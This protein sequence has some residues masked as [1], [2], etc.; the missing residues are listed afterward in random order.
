MTATSH[1]HT[2]GRFVGQKVPQRPRLLTGHG[3]YIDDVTVTGMLHA[4]FVRSDLA[5]ARI[6]GIDVE[7]ARAAEGVAAV[8]TAA[9]LNDKVAVSMLPTLFQGA[10]DFMAP[11]VPLAADDV[12][13]V[14]DPVALVIA[15]SRYLAEDAAEL[16]EVDYEPL[17]AVVDYE[18]AAS[19]EPR[20]PEPAVERGDGDGRPRQRRAVR[21]LGQRRARHRPPA[22]LQHGADGVPRCRVELRPIRRDARRALLEPE[23]TRGGWCSAASPACPSTTYACRSATSAAASASSRSWGARSRRSCSPPTSCVAR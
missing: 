16:V 2:A 20:A 11:I 3:R 12:R 9:D 19:A 10:D 13:F 7:A 5:R 23:P 6:T 14:G 21:G 4:T 1:A 15:E 17:P 18:A 22:P 8:F